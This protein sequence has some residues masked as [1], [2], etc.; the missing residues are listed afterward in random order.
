M[1]GTYGPEWPLTYTDEEWAQAIDQHH[2]AERQREQTRRL[3]EHTSR[4]VAQMQEYADRG[5]TEVSEILTRLRLRLSEA[6]LD[7]YPFELELEPWLDIA[8]EALS[9]DCLPTRA[10]AQVFAHASHPSTA[11]EEYLTTYHCLP[12]HLVTIEEPDSGSSSPVHSDADSDDATTTEDD[13]LDSSQNDPS[14]P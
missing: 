9:R 8:S 1:G 4:K 5:N 11:L 7:P 2:L 3:W 6:P 13:E 14:E 10:I 12:D